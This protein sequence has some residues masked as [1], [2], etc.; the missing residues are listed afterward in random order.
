MNEEK[1]TEK[2]IVDLIN[3]HKKVNVKKPHIYKIVILSSFTTLC[4]VAFLYFA[5]SLFSSNTVT[6][7]YGKILSPS[8]GSITSQAVKVIGET[9]NLEPGQYVWLAVDKPKIGLC[10]PKEPKI[11][12]NTGFKTI[13]YEGGPKE[14]YTLSVYAVNKIINDQWQEWLDNEIYGGLPMPPDKR[15]LDSVRLILGEK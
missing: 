7:I 15:R 6:D 8:A 9:K 4:L 14:P 12:P 11:L 10:W 1:N 3:K 13:I 2:R 5:T